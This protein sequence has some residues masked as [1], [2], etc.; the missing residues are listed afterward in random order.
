MLIIYNVYLICAKVKLDTVAA[1]LLSSM[2]QR[3][4]SIRTHFYVL[5]MM[6]FCVT[7]VLFSY[8]ELDSDLSSFS[9]ETSLN[10]I[11]IFMVDTRPPTNISEYHTIVAS[12]SNYY[13]FKHNCQFIYYHAKCD[14]A[15]CYGYENISVPAAWMKIKGI[16]Q[17]LDTKMK[18]GD[19][20]MYIDTDVL[21]NHSTNL[22]DFIAN[23]LNNSLIDGQ[24]KIALCWDSGSYWTYYSENIYKYPINTGTILFYK[25]QTVVV[26][27]NKWWESIVYPSKM[28][29]NPELINDDDNDTKWTNHALNWPFEQDRLSH[30]VETQLFVND[31]VLFKEERMIHP[32]ISN[33]LTTLE[34]SAWKQNNFIRN[35]AKLIFI[36]KCAINTSIDWENRKVILNDCDTNVDGIAIIRLL[37]MWAKRI[38]VIQ[39]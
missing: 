19:L 29:L 1:T 14:N 22:Q 30:I 11:F 20:A 26:L 23:D 7:V 24:P 37:D 34:S 35:Y 32:S 16:L 13:C 8:V 25:T 17:I 12:L 5:I 4:L 38:N 18:D 33:H 10:Q 21:L 3:C 39:I 31:I 36:D 9:T 2:S 27:M 15:H 28:D 6:V